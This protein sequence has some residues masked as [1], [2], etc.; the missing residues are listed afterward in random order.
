MWAS[1]V[2]HHQALAPQACLSCSPLHNR[3]ARTGQTYG[4]LWLLAGW[5]I[6]WQ[7]IRCSLYSFTLWPSSRSWVAKGVHSV[8]ILL[9]PLR[10]NTS[11]ISCFTIMSDDGPLDWN[12]ETPTLP[13]CNCINKLH[14]SWR[15]EGFLAKDSASG[16]V[17]MLDILFAQLK[18]T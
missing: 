18:E 4:W 17:F 3:W 8:N 10:E 2:T 6:V 9:M 14:R 7:H 11:R 16:L 12:K 15:L 1:S 13:V 5:P